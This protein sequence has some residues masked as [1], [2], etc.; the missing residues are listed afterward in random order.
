MIGFQHLGFGAVL[1]ISATTAAIA[2]SR[3]HNLDY[4]DVKD[5]KAVVIG[6]IENYHLVWNTFEAGTRVA[7]Q[8]NIVVD[9]AL[10]GSVGERLQIS[11]DGGNYQLPTALLPG[12]Y[13]IALTDTNDPILYAP[14][15]KKPKELTVLQPICRRAFLFL[16][17]SGDAE[18]TITALAKP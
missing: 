4:A 2:C 17:N 11:W 15:M 13:L 3:P 6:R 7:A 12:S 5:A 8:F 1:L 18:R 16:A 9:E 14:E 10:R